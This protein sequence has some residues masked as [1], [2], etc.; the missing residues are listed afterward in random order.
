MN[1]IEALSVGRLLRLALA[2]MAG[3]I[4]VFFKK[5]WF[6][7]A[8]IGLVVCWCVKND[9]VSLKIPSKKDTLTDRR[10]AQKLGMFES[11]VQSSLDKQKIIEIHHKIV[12]EDGFDA[13]G[14]IQEGVTARQMFYFALKSGATSSEEVIA[15]AKQVRKGQK[16]FSWQGLTN[17]IQ[18]HGNPI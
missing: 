18:E 3:K 8:M 16:T 7:V 12:D 1:N 6:V 14:E 10:T 9:I 5:N 17:F 15:I 11:N 2:K 13:L 4:F